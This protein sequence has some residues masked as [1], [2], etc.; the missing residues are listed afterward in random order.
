MAIGK[1]KVRGSL[2]AT[3]IMMGL[4]SIKVMKLAWS[5]RMSKSPLEFVEVTDSAFPSNRIELGE[6]SLTLKVGLGIVNF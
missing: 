4:F 1:V 2:S 5:A 6:A 3:L